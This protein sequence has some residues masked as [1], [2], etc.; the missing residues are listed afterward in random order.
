MPPGEW[1]FGR[2]LGRLIRD[3]ITGMLKLRCFAA[4]AAVFFGAGLGYCLEPEFSVSALWG[5]AAP[6]VQEPGPG[7]PAEPSS[8]ES[9][10]E[11][12]A[13]LS[14]PRLEG[15]APMT[16]GSESARE[17]IIAKMKAY[18]ISPAGDGG[19][20]LQDVRK[21]V[22]G[23][24]IGVNVV[25][26]VA[27]RSKP[28]ECVYLEAHYDHW[29]K[30]GGKVQPG[31]NDNASGVAMMLEL[32]RRLAAQGTDR[33]VIFLASDYEEGAALPMGGG[34]KGASYHAKH[35]A[36]PA[37]KIKAAVVLDMV[38]GS[39]VPGL[40]PH[41]YFI[42]S[43]S[44]AQ[45]YS[46]ARGLAGDPAKDSLARVM[47][48]YA[49]E[50]GGSGIPRAD[51]GPF[52]EIKVPFIFATSGIPPEYHTPEDTIDKV[53]FAF[54]ERAAGELLRI[55]EAMASAGFEPSFAADPDRITDWTAE[56]A[57]LE[58]I[59]DAIAA[60]PGFTEERQSYVERLKLDRAELKA[61][62]GKSAAKPGKLVKKAMTEAVMTIMRM[63][64]SLKLWEHLY[65]HH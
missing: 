28:E 22:F 56:L 61:E 26:R 40:A 29:G 1:A 4:A 12:V 32:G 3:I 24:R 42:G 21:N 37:D 55:L 52:R 33:T 63:N 9:M 54:M 59:V 31:A 64:G 49:I 48:V 53:D 5:S 60:I 65:R 8:A 25:G 16:K 14:D 27:G 46:L 35:P 41:L 45:T 17:H 36:C 39:F 2:F 51:Y 30:A 62:L 19:T 50:P 58:F 18:G 6:A 7:A 15:R 11:T 57:Q 10:R 38:G 43:E 13:F 34:L 23:N 44:S 47:G 20:F